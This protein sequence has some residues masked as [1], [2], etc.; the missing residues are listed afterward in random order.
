MARLLVDTNVVSYRHKRDSRAALY[1]LLLAGH[2]LYIAFSSIAELYEWAMRRRWGQR[3]VDDLRDTLADHVV[4][5]FDDELAW[6]WAEVRTITGR[7]IETGD[8]W[9]AAAALRHGLPLVTH[10]PR[11]FEHI[12]GL[13]IITAE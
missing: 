11:H 3:R 13:Q 9:I 2:T 5:P 12:P 7:P 10:N 4:I 1:E 6:R 8:A